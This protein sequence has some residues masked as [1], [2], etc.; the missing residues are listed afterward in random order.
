MK[1]GM[2]PTRYVELWTIPCKKSI[3]PR[4][5][6]IFTRPAILKAALRLRMPMRS[7]SRRKARAASAWPPIS[8]MRLS[9]SVIESCALGLLSADP[10]GNGKKGKQGDGG[11]EHEGVRRK[12]NRSFPAPVRLAYREAPGER[13]RLGSRSA[14][15]CRRQHGICGDSAA[16]A[17]S[18]RGRCCEERCNRWLA[19]K[20]PVKVRRARS[21]HEPKTEDP[22]EGLQDGRLEAEV[23]YAGAALLLSFGIIATTLRWMGEPI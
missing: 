5:R 11:P 9:V 3:S 7:S 1:R 15:A 12:R 17:G 10:G 13:R 16:V 14:R 23:A 22:M 19:R 8:T 2:V 18:G 21:P 20:Y 6:P 4:H